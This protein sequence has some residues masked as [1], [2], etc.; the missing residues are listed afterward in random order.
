MN[1]KDRTQKKSIKGHRWD[2][3]NFLEALKQMIQRYFTSEVE[4]SEA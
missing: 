2:V 3:K 4:N 1:Y